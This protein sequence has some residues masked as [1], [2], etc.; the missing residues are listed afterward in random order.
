[1]RMRRRG[2]KRERER[3][4]R[5]RR[6]GGRREEVERQHMEEKE[7]RKG[8]SL[9]ATA[10]RRRGTSER[11]CG[12]T[13]KSAMGGGGGGETD[14]TGRQ[15]RPGRPCSSS[16]RPPLPRCLRLCLPSRPTIPDSQRGRDTHRLLVFIA[17]GDPALRTVRLGCRRRRGLAVVERDIVD[18]LDRGLRDGAVVHRGGDVDGFHGGGWGGGLFE[19]RV[20]EGGWEMEWGWAELVWRAKSRQTQRRGRSA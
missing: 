7:G 15:S 17:L 18:A 9:H 5:E 6:G 12:E 10:R 8:V 3:E 4:S 11:A 19:W 1:M 16:R 20:Q 2:W 13:K 14:K